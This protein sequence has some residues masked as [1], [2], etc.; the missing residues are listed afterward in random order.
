VAG[1]RGE[2]VCAF[3]RQ[4]AEQAV[5]VAVPRLFVGLCGGVEQPPLG[6][7]V[8]KD[9][10]IVLPPECAGRSFRNVFTQEVVRPCECE[11][12][13]ALSLAGLFGRFPAALLERGDK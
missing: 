7:P 12:K 5:V 3:L 2:H 13:P 4:R 9:T 10:S 8:W 11:G 1:G 6:K